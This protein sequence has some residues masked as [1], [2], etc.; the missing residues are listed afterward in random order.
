[1]IQIQNATVG[2]GGPPVSTGITLEIPE[3]SVT[4]IVGPNGCGKSTA[5]R[6]L[7]RLLTPTTGTVLLDGADIR[8]MNEGAG[9]TAGSARTAV[10]G[11]G[12]DP[13]RGTRRARTLSAPESAATMVRRG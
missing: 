12:R 7:A 4:M 1:M 8:S 3:N 9:Q 10:V 11:T 6:T 13:S 5:L 2:Y